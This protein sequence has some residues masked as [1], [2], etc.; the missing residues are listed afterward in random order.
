LCVDVKLSRPKPL[1]IPGETW[2]G[3]WRR[4]HTDHI[5]TEGKRPAG[6]QTGDP[7]HTA[8]GG[9]LQVGGCGRGKS[10]SNVLLLKMIVWCSCKWCLFWLLFYMAAVSYY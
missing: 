2:L 6:G 10:E 4:W 9:V 7:A 1:S 3:Q 5:H 8:T